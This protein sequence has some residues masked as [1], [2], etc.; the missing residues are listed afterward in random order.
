M[1]VTHLKA[2][3]LA[4]H[5]RTVVPFPPML[6]LFG[7][8][9]R[10]VRLP[11]CFCVLALCGAGFQH[12]IAQIPAVAPATS[13]HH[14]LTLEVQ[15][16]AN[17]GTTQLLGNRVVGV[18]PADAVVVSAVGDRRVASNRTN[19]KISVRNL[20]T[21]PDTVRVE[22]FF[23][24]LPLH[25]AAA[26]NREIIFYHDAQ[27]LAIPGGKTAEQVVSSPEVRAVYERSTTVTTAPT[28]NSVFG[29]YTSTVS[30]SNVQTG[31]TIRGWMV[32]LVAEDGTVLAARGSSQTYE[33]VAA[34]SAR[35]AGMLAR[36]GP[37]GTNPPVS[38]AEGP[39]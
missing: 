7:R 24:A 19:I 34:N 1:I 29:D 27:P 21:G 8:S 16:V 28:G 23:V 9:G 3:I 15:S 39:R 33:E 37:A 17:G 26:G 22:W 38:R 4:R 18:N 14:S 36:P 25:E 31:L 10:E 5:Y 12:T 35:L 6:L 11:A 13:Q 20:S 32:R 2:K 30:S